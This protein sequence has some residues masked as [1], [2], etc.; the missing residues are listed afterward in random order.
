MLKGIIKK[1]IPKELIY[2]WLHQYYPDFKKPTTFNEKIISQVLNNPDL[3]YSKYADKVEVK[4]YVS[5][6]VGEKVVI[7]N[8]KVWDVKQE[9]SLKDIPYPSI[10]K[11]NHNSGPVFIIRDKEDITEE[12]VCS[13]NK[14][15]AED[16]G[17]VHGELWYSKIA[18]RIFAEQLLI[19]C[20]GDVPKDF[21]FH[22]FNKGGESKIIIQVDFGR[23]TDLKKTFYD[24]S[25]NILPYSLLMPTSHIEMEAPENFEEMLEIVCKLAAPFNYV[26]VDL[27][28]LSGRVYFGELTFA[29]GAG[30]QRFYPNK[31]DKLWGSYF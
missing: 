25:F 11:A 4:N 28:N 20:D 22:V 21:K 29:H 24:T 15:L 19:D 17:K 16:Y 9:V 6:V 27:Y 31:Y 2:F 1:I 12:L 10:L 14:Q 7:P 30:L 5:K 26:R 13:L 8:L 3:D 18:P 23:Y